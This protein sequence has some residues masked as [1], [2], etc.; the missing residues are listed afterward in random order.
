MSEQSAPEPGEIY[1]FRAPERTDDSKF[2]WIGLIEEVLREQMK[3][4]WFYLRD[5]EIKCKRQSARELLC[6]KETSEFLASVDS[7]AG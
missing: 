6:A 4:R 3:V 5:Q 1:F 7:R 2:P